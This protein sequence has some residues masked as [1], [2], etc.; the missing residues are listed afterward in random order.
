MIAEALG[1]ELVSTSMSA[2]GKSPGHAPL[3]ARWGGGRGG[4]IDGLN[5]AG[6]EDGCGGAAVRVSAPAW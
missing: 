5:A 2:F 3:I 6:V 1:E 4:W